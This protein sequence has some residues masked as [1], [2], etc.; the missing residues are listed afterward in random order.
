[1]NTHAIAVC[2]LVAAMSVAG[3]VSKGT[4]FTGS[5]APQLHEIAC[6]QSARSDNPWNIKNLYDCSTSTLYIPYQLWTGAKWD[7]SKTG[8][9]MH[10]ASASFTVNNRSDTHI[11]GPKQWTNP[12][13]GVTETVWS[14]EKRDGSKAQYFTCH[15]KGIGRVYD[16]RGPRYFASGR[17]KF[18]A[19]QG[20]ALSVKRDCLDTAI[21]ITSIALNE[22][23]ELE[24]IEF[25]WWTGRTLDH[26]YRYA[27]NVGMTDAWPQ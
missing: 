1:M 15:E 5:T 23:N 18:P 11:V 8:A 25:N 19:G 12:Q 13:S 27:T 21:E 9:C 7:G 26:R 17:C 3:T 2:V 24:S 20:W 22:K 14:R 16:S 10:D 4:Q 6:S